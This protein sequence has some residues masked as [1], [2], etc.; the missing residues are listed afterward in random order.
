MLHKQIWASVHSYKGYGVTVLRNVICTTMSEA[1]MPCIMP[2]HYDPGSALLLVSFVGP[3]GV[4]FNTVTMREEYTVYS[5][6]LN[7]LEEQN[8]STLCRMLSRRCD[9]I[10]FKAYKIWLRHVNHIPH[11]LWSVTKWMKWST[12]IPAHWLSRTHTNNDDL[13]LKHGHNATCMSKVN[14]SYMTQQATHHDHCTFHMN[15]FT[16]LK[17]KF[18][19]RQS[20]QKVRACGRKVDQLP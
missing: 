3:H 20:R 2:Q 5:L 17:G 9:F 11:S 13:S 18:S 16:W 4:C 7:I 12:K 10:T 15:H 6:L 1:V 8:N 14:R 19:K